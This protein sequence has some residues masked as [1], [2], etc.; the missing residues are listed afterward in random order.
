MNFN[1]NIKQVSCVKIPNLMVL[2][3]HYFAYFIYVENL[4]LKS[5]QLCLLVAFW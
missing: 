3:K 4:T 1:K 2:C 5:F